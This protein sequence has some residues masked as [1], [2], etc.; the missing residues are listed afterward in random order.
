MTLVVSEI[1]RHGI[2]MIGDSAI[3]NSIGGLPVGV[4]DGAAKIHYSEKSN[5]GFAIWGNAVIQGKQMDE[6]VKGFIESITDEEKDIRSVG[7]KLTSEIRIEL[8]KEKQPWSELIFGIHLA[9][10]CSFLD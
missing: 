3:T 8:E 4:G 1:S 5:I 2:I 7:Q 9:G 6:W 10:Y